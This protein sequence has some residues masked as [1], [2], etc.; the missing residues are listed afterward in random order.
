MSLEQKPFSLPE[1]IIDTRK[2]LI[3]ACK[4]GD[5]YAQKKLY[6]EYCD[7]MYNVCFRMVQNH[8]DASDILQNAFISIFKNIDKF[9]YE[10]T[11]GAWI[12]KIVV[13]H[14]MNHFRGR[15]VQFEELNDYD[16]TD[17]STIEI[18]PDLLEMGAI[19]K[20]INSLSDGYRSVV[21]LYLIEGYDHAEIAEVLGITVNTSKTQYHRAKK[22][23]RQ[24][25]EEYKIAC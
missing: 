13:N 22:K 8:D 5:R 2:D 21:N 19:K 14:C 12:K 3:E 7:A 11:P 20:A 6:E 17:E 9:K 23:L 24:L 25:L 15:K 1:T 4:S 10:S 16:T 18:E